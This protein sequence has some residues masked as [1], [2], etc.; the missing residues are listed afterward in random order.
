MNWIIDIRTAREN[1]NHHSHPSSHAFALGFA[2]LSSLYDINR[3]F[4]SNTC[5]EP[6]ARGQQRAKQEVDRCTPD[7][8]KPT[9]INRTDLRSQKK[10]EL[11]CQC[12]YS[13]H[14]Y[15]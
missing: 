7:V 11:Q 15:H 8:K 14:R 12:H 6:V 4:D 13:D 1:N 3:S 2:E 9:T 5:T 10:S